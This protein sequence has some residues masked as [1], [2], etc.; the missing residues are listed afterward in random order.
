MAADEGTPWWLW[1]LLGLVA[2]GALLAAVLVPRRRRREEWD[3]DLAA[4]EA[5]AAWLA[6][7]LLPRLESASTPDALAG[8]WLVSA[9]RVVAAEDRLTG[10][11]S[12]ATDDPRRAR[13]TR[14]RDGVRAARLGVEELVAARA[15]GSPAP[16]V[17]LL[18][19]RLEAVLAQPAPG[20]PGAPGDPSGPGDAPASGPA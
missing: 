6:R 2:L 3:A 19:A 7:D 18:A 14:L 5:E 13:A 10:L 8:G 12:T 9:G 11:A 15:P 17:A 1:L 16:Q 4:D 20:A